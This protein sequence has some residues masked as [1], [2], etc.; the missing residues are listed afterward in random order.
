MGWMI[1]VTT[2]PSRQAPLGVSARYAVIQTV[3]SSAFEPSD[4]FLPNVP[5]EFSVRESSWAATHGVL[6]AGCQYRVGPFEQVTA[7]AVAWSAVDIA[8][9]KGRQS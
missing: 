9:I 2:G 4:T 8:C 5:R 3:P 6:V 7:R 1:S